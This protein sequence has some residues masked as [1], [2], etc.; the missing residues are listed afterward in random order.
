MPSIGA[1]ELIVL[2]FVALLLFGP[3]RLPQVGR[4][5][6]QGMREF[7]DTITAVQSPEPVKAKAEPLNPP[8]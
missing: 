1:P 4:S 7:K 5:I 8:S 2:L 6:G 3:K